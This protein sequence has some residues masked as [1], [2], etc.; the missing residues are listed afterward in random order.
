MHG[1]CTHFLLG[2]GN[3]EMR[4]MYIFKHL[5]WENWL[6]VHTKWK[7]LVQLQCSNIGILR[8]WQNSYEWYPL[9]LIFHPYNYNN[10]WLLT[11]WLQ[12]HWC[13]W[14]R[15]WA[16]LRWKTGKGKRISTGTGETVGSYSG[17]YGWGLMTI[18]EGGTSMLETSKP[19]FWRIF[20]IRCHCYATSLARTHCLESCRY[21]TSTLNQQL[22]RD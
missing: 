8:C 4:E 16:S 14:R 17:W 2:T 5:N 7:Y 20:A 13:I 6:N 21:W 18:F 15:S 10:H 12:L 1:C 11:R 19:R 9:I 3:A 22:R